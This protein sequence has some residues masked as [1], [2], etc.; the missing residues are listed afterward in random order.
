MREST[1]WLVQAKSDIGAANKLAGG[2]TQPEMYCQV[3][4]KAQQAVE[5]SVKALQSALH[6][7]GLFGSAVGSA[8]QVSRVASAIRAAAP[9]WPK[10][11]KAQRDKVTSIL[12]DAR[13]QTIK[14][15]D[16]IVPQYPAPG[17][18]PK[19]NTEYPF[20][21]VAG[22]DTFRAPAEPAVFSKKEVERFLNCARQLQLMT[23]K[24]VTALEQ[25]YP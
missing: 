5:K 21:V 25:A 14:A 15:L 23:D 7:A 12:S 20:Q 9:G 24:V 11:L 13:L 17:D 2:W 1:A 6:H 19:R 8:H 18:L 16:A 3:A 22:R 4:A 10:A